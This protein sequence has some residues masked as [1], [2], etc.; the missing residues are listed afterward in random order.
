MPIIEDV[1]KYKSKTLIT[2]G[3]PMFLLAVLISAASHQY[4]HFLSDKILTG[5]AK[6]AD[7]MPSSINLHGIQSISP[8]A[9]AAGPIWTFIL[10]LLSFGYYV[11]NPKNLF[12][13][14]MAFVN[15]SCRLPETVTLFLQLLLHNKTTLLTDESFSLALLKLDDPTISIVLLCFFSLTLLFLTITIIHDTKMVPWKWLIA[16]ILFVCLIP[17]QDFIWKVFASAVI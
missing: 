8:L 3:I 4:I 10:A 16:F 9:A 11:H 7:T 13:A 6:V 12:A 15:A 5:S 14:S 17:M 1:P 2:I